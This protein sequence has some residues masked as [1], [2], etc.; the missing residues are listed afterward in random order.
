L[1]DSKE[2]VEG[3]SIPQHYPIIRR[4]AR[5]RCGAATRSGA[6]CQAP[7]VRGGARCRQHGGNSVGEAHNQRARTHGFYTKTLS[8]E[9]IADL[10][11]I[12][13]DGLG[14]IDHEVLT[15]KLTVRRIER[16]RAAA[17]L[18]PDG[19]EV[20]KRH[21]R[22]ASE[23]GPG[24]ETVSE[25]VDYPGL[26]DRAVRTAL[27]AVDKREDLIERRAERAAR[28]SNGVDDGPITEFTV[29]VVTAENVHLYQDGDEA[30][31]GGEE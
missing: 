5:A 15:A 7:A 14:D 21:D 31:Q 9:D 27:V 3:D 12:M 23:Y 11:A 1:T 26:S 17:A 6:S 19:L 28:E 13:A 10:D 29:H 25:R 16:A 2:T 22:E 30:E 8:A 4:R 24:D 20:I 18:L